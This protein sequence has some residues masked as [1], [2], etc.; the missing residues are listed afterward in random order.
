MRTTVTCKTCRRLRISVCGREKCAF[1][2][3]PYPPGVHGKAFR[4][5]GSEFGVQLAEKQKL[6]F[7]YGLRE[8]QFRNYVQ[9]ALKQK[10]VGT[11]D[12]IINALESRL[13]NAVYRLGFSPTRAAARQVV[14]HGHVQVNG[15]RV[16]IPSYSLKIGDEVKLREASKQ[17]GPFMNLEILI[18]KAAPPSWLELDRVSY[19]GKMTAPPSGEGL[20]KGYNMNAIV[21]YY[22]R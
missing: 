16:N 7:L 8:R 14:N 10:G 22:S 1:K 13:D 4:R 17:K 12:A 3:K 21:E 15:K 2:R 6:K 5:A 19:A 18:K 11:S 9:G 20:G